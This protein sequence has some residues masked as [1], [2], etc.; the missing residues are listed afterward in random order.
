MI[1]LVIPGIPPS[2]N[3]AYFSKGNVRVLTKDGLSFKNECKQLLSTKYNKEM[4]FFKPNKGYDFVYIFKCPDIF[5]ASY[6]EN[7]KISKYKKFDV[8]N[9][10]KLIEDC[11]QEI[12]GYDDSQNETVVAHKI[13]SSTYETLV[14]VWSIEEESNHVRNLLAALA[15]NKP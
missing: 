3:H 11:F 2:S 15:I 9:R 8:S 1:H 4:G 7:G 6:K 14:W 13:H 10:V 5:N 12:G